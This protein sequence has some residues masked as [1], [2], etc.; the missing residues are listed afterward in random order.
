MVTVIRLAAIA[1]ILGACHDRPGPN[2]LLV[3]SSAG[4]AVGTPIYR[5]TTTIGF[6]SRARPAG[7]Q[8][9]ITFGFAE[10][11][12]T[13]PSLADVRLRSGG[14]GAR[15]VFDLPAARVVPVFGPGGHFPGGG[16]P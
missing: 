6:V 13:P 3:P 4:V 15:P 8:L 16:R 7:D 5:G 10:D 1:G 2:D 9:R 14:L 12:L 11:S